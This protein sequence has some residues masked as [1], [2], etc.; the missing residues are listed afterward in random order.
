MCFAEGLS[1][2][3]A[4]L[5]SLQKELDHLKATTQRMVMMETELAVSNEHL[6][7]MSQ[8]VERARAASQRLE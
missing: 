8:E 3:E 7:A 1:R 5:T 2:K 4:A 6:M